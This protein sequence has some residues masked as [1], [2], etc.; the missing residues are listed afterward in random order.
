[1][2]NLL[3]ILILGLCSCNH[4]K[5]SKASETTQSSDSIIAS[6]DIYYP[7]YQS[8]ASHI[9]PEENTDITLKF[10]RNTDMD[11]LSL[12]PL[13]IPSQTKGR[14]I[15]E[16]DPYKL[17]AIDKM[18][19][20]ELFKTKITDFPSD[21]MYVL[22]RINHDQT[23]DIYFWYDKIIMSIN[24]DGSITKFENILGKGE[25]GSIKKGT[26]G[27]NIFSYISDWRKE[28]LQEYGC[29]EQYEGHYNSNPYSVCA[30]RI[31]L[32]NDSVIID[33]LK[34]YSPLWPEDKARWEENDHLLLK[35]DVKKRGSKIL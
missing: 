14:D 30:T 31:V 13:M 15:L 16:Y 1:M 18:F 9:F 3:F 8:G 34:F 12:F 10:E 27:L 4:I 19:D 21:T 35:K 28:E 22:E 20:I 29:C 11:L 6:T 25:L 33:M 7:K 26:N 23:Y 5:N 17:K 2:K 32:T 24:D